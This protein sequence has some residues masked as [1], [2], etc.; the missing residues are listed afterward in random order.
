MLLDPSCGGAMHVKVSTGHQR[1]HQPNCTPLLPPFWSLACLLPLLIA[2]HATP[3]TPF[4]ST[5]ACTCHAHAHARA[6]THIFACART[7]ARPLSLCTFERPCFAATAFSPRAMACCSAAEAWAPA[8]RSA[9]ALPCGSAPKRAA[10]ACA[11]SRVNRL[12]CRR[13]LCVEL[14]TCVGS[15][16]GGAHILVGDGKASITVGWQT[17]DGAGKDDGPRMHDVPMLQLSPMH[18]PPPTL[19]GMGDWERSSSTIQV[20]APCTAFSTTRTAPHGMAALPA[21]AHTQ[22]AL[23][24]GPRELVRLLPW[25]LGAEVIDAPCRRGHEGQRCS[26]TGAR[27]R[28]PDSIVGWC[29]ELWH[30]SCCHLL[31]QSWH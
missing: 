10:Q 6:H 29:L 5:P 17:G 15:G 7:Q 30:S 20:R 16:G 9:S 26:A 22:H 24:H 8:P 2:R 18:A 23:V 31:P 11:F 27:R 1:A 13:A 25:R 14:C 3:C 28:V 12:V 4:L 21:R 19:E